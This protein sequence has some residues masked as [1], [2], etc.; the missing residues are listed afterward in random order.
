MAMENFGTVNVRM[1]TPFV[2]EA[3]L[4][5]FSTTVFPDIQR[6]FTVVPAG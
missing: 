6:K 3:A 4:F 5:K 2:L 1:A